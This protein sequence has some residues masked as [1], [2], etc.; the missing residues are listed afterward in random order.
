MSMYIYIYIY[1]VEEYSAPTFK[2]RLVLTGFRGVGLGS[3]PTAAVTTAYCGLVFSVEGFWVQGAV[4]M[5][6]P[7]LQNRSHDA[8]QSSP[9]SGGDRVE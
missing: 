3:N 4:A 1:I 6:P 9:H 8:T 5:I 2:G 7:I